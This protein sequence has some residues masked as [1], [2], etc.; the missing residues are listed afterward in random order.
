MFR[1]PRFLVAALL[2]ALVGLL[3]GS[4]PGLQ[5]PTLA[6]APGSLP[7][8]T[9]SGPRTI[10]APYIPVSDIPV[11]KFAEMGI[12]WFGKVTTAQN[13]TDVRVGYNDSALFVMATVLDR[14]IWYDPA[15]NPAK[16]TA[17]DG[18]SLTLNLGAATGA[19]NTS[20]FRFD[21]QVSAGE[22]D[23]T[24]W[25]IAYR[26]TGST[27]QRDDSISFTSRRG[28]AG[29]T[30]GG[31]PTNGW[32]I[33]F[34]I[35]FES[36]GVA[37]KPADLTAWG[38]GL[39]MHDRDTKLGTPT[40][41]Y[42]PEGS[43]VT[44]P[45]TFGRLVFGMPTYTPPPYTP[46]G[47]PIEIRHKKDGVKVVDAGV[48]GNLG[49]PTK[50]SHLCGGGNVTRWTLWGNYNYAGAHDT[51][52]QNQSNPH[53]F[54]CFAKFYISFPLSTMPR[55]KVIVSA[56]L[57]MHMYG[58]SAWTEAEDSLIQVSTI[59]NNFTES[60]IT[61]NNAPLAQENVAQTWV[62]VIRTNTTPPWPGIRYEWDVSRAV[63]EAYQ[64]N[65][66]LRLAIYEAD[67]KMHSGKYFTTSNTGD[68]EGWNNEGRPTLVIEWGDPQ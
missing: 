62:E 11:E 49:S 4:T 6:A 44:R 12:F 27:W 18:F 22:Q 26:G 38:M 21:A 45:S 20:S 10:N 30:N 24:P 60:T 57:V 28:L 66:P 43:L 50:G 46:G 2:F 33:T 64:A 61:W 41:K 29:Y 59:K 37:G 39:V 16:I 15:H 54:P 65:L 67:S 14:M 5:Q 40:H 31:S 8:S 25:Q 1:P 47:E 9:I 55:G 13:Y 7:Q 32:A 23:R 17:Y 3:V 48:G 42:W 63:A 19:P 53:D 34:I 52:I 35:P 36:L 51:V 68:P 56:K 58:G